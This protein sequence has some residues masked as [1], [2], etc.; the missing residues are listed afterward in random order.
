MSG[1][2]P[3]TEADLYDVPTAGVE[4]VGVDPEFLQFEEEETANDEEIARQLQREMLMAAGNVVA[5][6]QSAMERQ[7][8]L[9][10]KKTY[11]GQ[12]FGLDHKVK[13]FFI[14][15]VILICSVVMVIEL[16]VNREREGDFFD[17]FQV[18]PLFGPSLDT[19][20][21]LGAK[22]TDLIVDEGDWWRLLIPIILHGGLLHLAFNL[23][24][25]WSFGTGLEA[26]FGH[27]RVIYIFIVSG[28]FGVIC[29]SIFNPTLVSVGAS[30]ACYGLI[31]AAWAEFWLNFGFYKK[32]KWVSWLVQLTFG[33]VLNVAL[34]LIPT[35]DNFAHLGGLFAGFFTGLTV[36]TLP[37]YDFLLEVKPDQCY[38][39][40]LRT[41][42]IFITLIVLIVCLII[43]Y[44]GVDANEYCPWCT[45]LTCVPTPF[46][47]CDIECSEGFALD[48]QIDGSVIIECPRDIGLVTV[49]AELV[50]DLSG[51]DSAQFAFCEEHC[52][53]R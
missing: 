2:P 15:F 18:N 44:V 21:F 53:G 7:Q 38:Q 37:R 47:F 23:L 28:F 40:F 49:P 24:F 32:T 35:L 30:G 36:L 41:V 26:E 29:S 3:L 20:I 42:G 46:W 4:I 52:L 31:G 39:V 25:L 43:L 14:Y 51:D 1:V 45:Y 22:R 5:R 33:T 12:Q 11:S 6:T 9:L 19:L 16:F 34:G 13:P 8:N 27:P 17:D 48:I 10:A 50:P